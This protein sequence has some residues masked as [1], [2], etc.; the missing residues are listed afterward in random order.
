MHHLF[1]KSLFLL[2]LAGLFSCYY[3][4]NFK[5]EVTYNKKT[6]E[7]ITS[8]QLIQI[9]HGNAKIDGKY[10]DVGFRVTD[11]YKV[12]REKNSIKKNFLSVLISGH[13]LFFPQSIYF[14]IENQKEKLLLTTSDWKTFRSGSSFV[15]E[16]TDVE[17]NEN[18]QLLLDELDGAIENRLSIKLRMVGKNY[19]Q[20]V[21]LSNTHRI[22]VVLL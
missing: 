22:R 13:N 5:P 15:G 20:I 19:E 16:H 2:L 8:L 21:T 1:K 6:G 12:V 14:T 18:I 10:V 11:I 17:I 9:E 3:T 7:T 4:G